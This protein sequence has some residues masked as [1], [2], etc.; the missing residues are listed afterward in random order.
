MTRRVVSFL[1][2]IDGCPYAAGSNGCPSSVTSTDTDYPSGVVVL[3]GALD[4]SKLRSLS[5]SESIKPVTGETTVDSITLALV[6]E[7]VASGPATGERPWS[8][9]FS[10]RSRAIL[11]APL[12]TSINDTASSIVV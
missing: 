2:T 11:R 5:W 1:L 12:A 4:S 7:R 9:L 10:R 8:W 6:D 3:P